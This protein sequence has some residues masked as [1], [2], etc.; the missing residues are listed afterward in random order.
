MGRQ[1]KNLSECLSYLEAAHPL[2]IDLGL[3]R[4]KIVAARM[5]PAHFSCPVISVAGTNGKGTTVAVLEAIARLKGLNVASYT[6]PHIWHFNE[7]IKINQQP[8]SDDEII[9]AFSIVEEA[10]GSVS[11]SYFEAI[12]LA[13]LW[14]FHQKNLDLIVLEVGMGGRL[15][16]TNL[17]DAD[18][19]VITSISFDHQDY[20]GN[21]LEAIATEK[22]GIMRAGK[23]V[24]C[25]ELALAYYLQEQARQYGAIFHMIDAHHNYDSINTSLVSSNIAC[26][27]KAAALSGHP[28][29]M[30]DL[31]TVVQSMR[32]PGRA[33]QINV[34][35]KKV[36]LDVAHNTASIQ[37]LTQYIATHIL[38]A[39][40]R[41]ILVLG[42]LADKMMDEAIDQ[43]CD[44]VDIIICAT[45]QISRGL[46]AIELKHR[47]ARHALKISCIEDPQ[48]AFIHACDKASSQDQI[49][50]T[51]SFH[52]MPIY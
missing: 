34:N 50:V 42:I 2:A 16:A 24:V 6:S 29:S 3:D 23:P 36:L 43:L 17:I 7:R 18:V 33:D 49:I 10:R 12:T 38:S 32:I 44:Q 31:A 11:L 26:A 51:G 40:S 4:I 47:L 14:L 1:E 39:G 35:G 5:I 37:R 25:G 41:K 22:S 21:T 13:A 20:L 8:V 9:R 19:A 30:D 15:D 27:H 52:M 48:D 45:P 28:V 46:P